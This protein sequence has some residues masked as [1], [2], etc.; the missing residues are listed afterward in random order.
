MNGPRRFRKRPVDIDAMQWD[1][2]P[3]SATSII[4][5]VLDGAGT[6]RL[7][8]DE[9]CEG[10][11][12]THYIG[13]DTLDGTMMASAGDWVVCGVIGEFYPCKPDVFAVTYEEVES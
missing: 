11:A 3:E 10:T 7:I 2:T 1:G 12:G 8:C 4:D 9:G 5:W 6:A 13:V